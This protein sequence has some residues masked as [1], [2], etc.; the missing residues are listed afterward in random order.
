MSTAEDPFAAIEEDMMIS[1]CHADEGGCWQGPALAPLPIM[2]AKPAI[3][4]PLH[5]MALHARKP[6]R[7]VPQQQGVQS[8]LTLQH[9]EELFIKFAKFEKCDPT[10][11]P[12]LTLHRAGGAVHQ[13]CEG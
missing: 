7:P 8:R 6:C 12:Q 9:A 3:Y 11:I 2:H 13:A 1:H 5:G 4:A 10:A